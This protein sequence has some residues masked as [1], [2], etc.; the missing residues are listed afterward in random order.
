MLTAI[1]MV[2]PLSAVPMESAWSTS[3]RPPV[4]AGHRPFYTPSE[5]GGLGNIRL[6][7]CSWTKLAIFTAL[8]STAGST[9]A[10]R[11]TNC[12]LPVQAGNLPRST[13]SAALMEDPTT[14][15]RS[16]MET[17]T[18]LPKRKVRMASARYSSYL[19]QSAAGPLPTFTTSSAAATAHSLTAAEASIAM[20]MSLA[21]PTQAEAGTRASCLR[22]RREPCR[23]R[24]HD[25]EI[26][27]EKATCGPCGL[28]LL[29]PTCCLVGPQ[30]S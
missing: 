13:A 20:E 6:E 4:P 12:R 1:F 14:S 24:E 10:A 9:A 30:V 25:I 28:S 27:G 16:P 2:R 5:A 7:A 18:A 15:S 17:F 19:R 23:Q 22:S 3:F 8:L 21:Q 29:P 26:V 11:C